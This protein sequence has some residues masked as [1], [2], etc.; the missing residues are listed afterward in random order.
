MAAK[1]KPPKVGVGDFVLVVEND[2]GEA[3]ATMLLPDWSRAPLAGEIVTVPRSFAA[4][5]P[6]LKP[7]ARYT[8]NRVEHLPP[9]D[10]T[11]T[12]GD[13]TLPW[14][15]ARRLAYA[16]VTAQGAPGPGPET[17]KSIDGPLDQTTAAELS[18]QSRGIA[19]ELGTLAEEIAVAFHTGKAGSIGLDV[20][21]RID[22]ASRL[23]KQVSMSVLL[24][25]RIRR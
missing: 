25:T 5:F 9:P 10:A 6:H 17:P 15:F 23:A 11:H 2:A 20:V 13:F 7:A 16:S 19:T 21:K 18:E 3:S 8:V 22:E 1:R 14:C 12:I 24:N 4:R